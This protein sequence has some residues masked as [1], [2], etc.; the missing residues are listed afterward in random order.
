MIPDTYIIHLVMLSFPYFD[1]HKEKLTF[2]KIYE[3][4]LKVLH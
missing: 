1:T 4:D 3:I 2:Y